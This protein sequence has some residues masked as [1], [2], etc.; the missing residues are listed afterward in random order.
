MIFKYESLTL[1]TQREMNE[2]LL[3]LQHHVKSFVEHKQ[4]FHI[5][6]LQ[7]LRKRGDCVMLVSD[8]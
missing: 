3:F 8:N 4:F 7:N 6:R 5:Q 1:C 2:N